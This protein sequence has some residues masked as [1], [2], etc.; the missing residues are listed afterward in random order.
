MQIVLFYWSPPYLSLYNFTFIKYNAFA[1]GGEW[2]LLYLM[3]I[4]S[5]LVITEFLQTPQGAG[6][7]PKTFFVLNGVRIV[8][9][10]KL[11][12]L[13]ALF[14]QSVSLDVVKMTL[15]SVLRECLIC[16]SP[17]M[18]RKCDNE[19]GKLLPQSCNLCGTR[20]WL[21]SWCQIRVLS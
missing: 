1:L 8:L 14:V 21:I 9:S 16:Y 19:Q 5:L 7:T 11:V 13:W 3:E 15:L 2:K 10:L 6:G 4:N 18:V 20:A 17:V 12:N